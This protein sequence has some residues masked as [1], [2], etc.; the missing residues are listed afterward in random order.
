MANTWWWWCVCPSIYELREKLWKLNSVRSVDN[1]NMTHQVWCV[2]SNALSPNPPPPPELLTCNFRGVHIESMCN[3]H[4]LLENASP[5]DV[6]EASVKRCQPES[7]K[8][9]TMGLPPENVRVDYKTRK[10]PNHFQSFASGFP[11]L[12]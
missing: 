11:I 6:K 1:E 7:P 8:S 12:S 2:F 3:V 10:I 4:K 9:L 5:F